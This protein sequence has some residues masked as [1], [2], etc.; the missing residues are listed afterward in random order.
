[1]LPVMYSLVFGI[2]LQLA[3]Q[4]GTLQELQQNKI[5]F[6][7]LFILFTILSYIQQLFGDLEVQ[8]TLLLGPLFSPLHM[9]FL[10]RGA[11]HTQILEDRR[12]L[13]ALAV[14]RWFGKLTDGLCSQRKSF[15]PCSNF[16]IQVA[17]IQS[18]LSS[19]NDDSAILFHVPSESIALAKTEIIG[20]TGAR[21]L[22]C[23][24]FLSFIFSVSGFGIS[25]SFP[26]PMK[27]LPVRLLC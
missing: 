21:F 16:C 14:L 6:S 19:I 13:S 7:L 26:P 10:H 17:N 9:H 1:M 12:C 2:I 4:V 23:Y 11:K 15:L 24:F 27:L 5:E 22:Y 25:C 8:F 18:W 3:T 20:D